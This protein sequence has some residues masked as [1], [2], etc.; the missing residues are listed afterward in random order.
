MKNIYFWYNI[1][2]TGQGF[3]IFDVLIKF[4]NKIQLNN[5]GKRKFWFNV[6]VNLRNNCVIHPE[7][8]FSDPT[9][10]N[11]FFRFFQFFRYLSRHNKFF[12]NF[13]QKRLFYFIYR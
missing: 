10:N 9:G 11:H 1:F 5:I 3:A 4:I 12:G 2:R 8:I 7:K 6:L 13:F